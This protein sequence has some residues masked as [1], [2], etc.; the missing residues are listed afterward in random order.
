MKKIGFII[1]MLLLL[2]NFGIAQ[3]LITL[4]DVWQK[5]TFS[6]KAAPGFN[7]MND[8]RHYT[9]QNGNA[10]QQ[11]DLT[12]GSLMQ[13]IL[14]A[15]PLSGT[16]GFNGQMRDY[17]F[18]ADKQKV[19]VMSELEPLYRRSFKGKFFVYDRTTKALEPIFEGG[20]VSLAKFNP[21]GTKVAYL[22]DNNLY[23]KDLDSDKTVQVTTDGKFNSIINGG[24]DWVYEEEF[25]LE[26]G[27][28]W[29]PDGQRLAFLRFD[30]SAVKEFV[31]QMYNNELYPNNVTFKYP[32]V[33]ET[34]ST[35]TV[36]IYDLNSNKTV[37]ADANPEAD[38][39]IPR[40]YWTPDA[41]QLCILRMNRLQNQ[42][43]FL[44]A[45]A[46]SGATKKIFTELNSKYYIDEAILDNITFLKNGSGF[47]FTSERDGWRHIYF[48]DM[49]GNK[50]RQ[51]TK[52][53]WEVSNV[54]GVDEQRG[55]VYFQSAEKSPMER[56]VYS[57]SLDGKGKKTLAGNAGWN[58][59]NFSST[60]DYYVLTSSSINTPA[61]YAVYD[62]SGKQ[63]R[64][65]EDNIALKSKMTEFRLSNS[66]FFK[67]KTSENV[68]LNG[69]MIKPMNFLEN[70]KYPVLM[71]VY[72]GPGSQQ[73][74]DRFSGGNYWWF[75]MLAQQGYLVACVDNRG[76]G[77][78]GE[79]FK[80][81]TYLQLGKYETIDQIEAAKWLGNQSFVDK[82][83]IGIFGWSYGGYM[84]SLCIFKGADVFNAAIAVAPVTNWKWYD[85]VYTERFMQTEASNGAGYRENSP[86]YFADKLKGDYL[87]VHGMGDDN[88]HFQNTAEMANALIKANKQ[89]DTYFYP[90]RNHGIAGGNTRLHLYTKMTN[91]LNEKLKG[92]EVELTPK[93]PMP[94]KKLEEFPKQ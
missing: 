72:G 66:E 7:F 27:Y 2:T 86:V 33:G 78:R 61:T 67:F 71:F 50:A 53:N 94:A 31:M 49:N 68:E 42:L 77:A 54:Y 63:L 38:Q 69:W 15:T 59:A 88:V 34:N 40:I 57:V 83:R 26:Q 37:K 47:L 82:N 74:V 48:H 19:L 36:H 85:S 29:S 90:N 56:Q 60:F 17:E 41:K 14:D 55:L 76:T 92:V 22:F 18:S 32:K 12:T 20:K 30:E 84:S 10:I 81:M 35:V 39:Y 3:K 65:V 21:Q 58:D 24:M 43:D 11:Y 93:K 23:I 46:M 16:A 80:K 87:L 79:E 6:A 8:G 91:F 44:L 89:Y 70:R 4:E 25:S 75:Q 5:G 52:G 73:V 45:D 1:S 64:V 51:L 13:T 62:Q 9:L 28:D